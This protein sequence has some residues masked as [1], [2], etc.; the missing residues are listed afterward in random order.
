MSFDEQFLIQQLKEG[1]EQAYRWLFSQHYAPLCMYAGRLLHD[2][3]LAESIV[4]DVIYHIWEIRDYIEITTSLHS[5]LMRSVRNRCTDHLQSLRT[6]TEH[7][8]SSLGKADTERT[9]N[10]TD[11]SQPQGILIEKELE[12]AVARAI[13]A[14][15]E[16]CRAVFKASRIEGKRYEDIARE[17]GLSVNTVKYH[18]K[19][20]LRLLRRDLARY[21][22]AI[23]VMVTAEL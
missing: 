3:A 1:N 11:T 7:S 19:N 15:P 8:V 16:Q 14:L 20:A 13:E 4:D 22:T 17:T 5:Y 2:N 23:L 10:Y 9:L 21:I 12:E 6:R 18:V